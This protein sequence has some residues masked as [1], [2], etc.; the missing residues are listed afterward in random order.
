MA[1]S[2]LCCACPR[3]SASMWA[4]STGCWPPSVSVR[5]AIMEQIMDF[6]EVMRRRRM[7]R[8]YTD[9]P[10]SREVLER[11]VDR[12]RRAPSGGFSQG[13]RF[14][15]VTDQETRA[16]IAELAGEE[17]YY[18]SSGFFEPWISRAPAHIVVAMREDDYHD[19]YTKPDK[20]EAAGGK[21][22]EWRVPWWWVD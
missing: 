17:R 12:G 21:E 3:K 5:N 14:V 19:R 11:I 22:V 13:N 16:R 18:T 1:M 9:E 2:R 8:N 20:L 6:S 4:M 10:V 15:V 7:V